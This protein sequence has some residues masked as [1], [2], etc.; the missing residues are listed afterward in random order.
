MDLYIL[1]DGVSVLCASAGDKTTVTSLLD[2]GADPHFR[3]I[4]R[5]SFKTRLTVDI[6]KDFCGISDDGLYV[7][8][9]YMCGHKYACHLLQICTVSIFRPSPSTC[10]WS[11]YWHLWVP[12]VMRAIEHLWRE[13]SWK[14]RL[15]VHVH[16]HSH[17]VLFCVDL[18]CCVLCYICTHIMYLCTHSMYIYMCAPFFDSH[19][20]YM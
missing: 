8:V 9:H 5:K 20:T 12:K 2:S 15:H 17:S 18:V 4:V 14:L 3:S 7:H 11:L 1:Q 16:G 13:K 6:T 19:W 10:D